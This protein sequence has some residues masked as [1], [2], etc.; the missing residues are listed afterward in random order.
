MCSNKSVGGLGFRK[1]QD[2]NKALLG[3]Q[4]WRLIVN[5]DSLA[6]K[7]YKARYYPNGSFLQATVGNNPSYIWRS[8][9]ESQ[10]L[11]KKGAVRRVGKGT[12]I[13]IL[14]DPWLPGHDTY[15]QTVHDAL[16]GKTVDSL[17]NLDQSGWDIDLL[18]DIFED[19]DIQLILSIPLNTTNEDVWYWNREKIGQYTVKS[20]DAV[21]QEDRIVD[22]QVDTEWWKRMWNLQVPLRVKHFMWRATRDVLPTKDQLLTKRVLVLEFCP[23]CNEGKESVCYLSFCKVM[24]E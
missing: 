6:S 11:L 20:A 2:F 15:V 3:K 12:T 24:L 21:I 5:M 9:M 4:G 17:M 23:I 1:L 18:H 7:V 8:I 10:V 16:R 13:D 19:R 22:Q 14:N